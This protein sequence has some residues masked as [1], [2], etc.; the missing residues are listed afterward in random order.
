M[1]N[2]G[3]LPWQSFHQKF[4]DFCCLLKSA[5]NTNPVPW[6]LERSKKFD[7]NGN[8]LAITSLSDINNKKYMLEIN[9]TMN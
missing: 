9:F 2:F 3:T 1:C 6:A 5:K 7:L 8:E 4:A